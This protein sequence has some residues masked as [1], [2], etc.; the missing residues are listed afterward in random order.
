MEELRVRYPVQLRTVYYLV[1]TLP[2]Y[3]HFLA[4]INILDIIACTCTL[5]V[6]PV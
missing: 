5:H 1:P 2:T 4:L 6:P 3:A